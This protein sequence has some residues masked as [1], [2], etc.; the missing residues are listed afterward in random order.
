MCEG[1]LSDRESSGREEKK[2]GMLD[3]SGKTYMKAAAR[4]WCVSKKWEQG[5][6]KRAMGGTKEAKEQFRTSLEL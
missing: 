3:P 2:V 6:N 1:K 5:L 4:W